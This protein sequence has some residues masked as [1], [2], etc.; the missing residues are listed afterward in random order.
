MLRDALAI[1]GGVVLFYT[2]CVGACRIMDA[3]VRGSR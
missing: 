3:I 1:F 2:L